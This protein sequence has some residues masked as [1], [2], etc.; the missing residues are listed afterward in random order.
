MLY[1]CCFLQNCHQTSQGMTTRHERHDKQPSPT[2]RM[3]PMKDNIA[4]SL[5]QYC[6]MRER[7]KVAGFTSNMSF[8]QQSC[9]VCHPSTIIISSPLLSSFLPFLLR[10]A[11]P[12]TSNEVTNISSSTLRATSQLHRGRFSTWRPCHGFMVTWIPKQNVKYPNV[13]F[14][15]SIIACLC[16]NQP[17][18]ERRILGVEKTIYYIMYE[19]S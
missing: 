5:Q 14:N 8:E 9:S 6:A 3:S 18:K 16:L 12:V 17:R 7:I 15:S 2:S 4:M 11:F 19:H 1:L 13:D 10:L